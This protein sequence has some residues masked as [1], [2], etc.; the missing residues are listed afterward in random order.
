MVD[1][2]GAGDCLQGGVQGKEAGLSRGASGGF[3]RDVLRDTGGLPRGI[4]NIMISV[5]HHCKINLI[6]TSKSSLFEEFSL[7]WE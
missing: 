6:A 2:Q 1:L 5:D 3:S 7:A 4:F